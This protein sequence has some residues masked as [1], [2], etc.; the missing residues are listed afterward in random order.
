MNLVFFT[1][2]DPFYVKAF[3]DEFLQ[4][5]TFLDEIK[6]I[7]ISKSM[8]KKSALK[9]AQQMYDFYGFYNFLRVGSQYSYRKLMGRKIVRNNGYK[10]IVKTYTLQQLARVYGLNVIERSDLNSRDFQD[11]IRQYNADLFISVAS[12]IIFKEELIK[13]PRLDCINIHHAPLPRYRGMMP[14]FWQIYHGESEVGITIHRINKGIDTGDIIIQNYI[15]VRENESLHKLMLR[16]KKEGARI[17]IQVIED[18][19]KGRISYKKMEGAGSYFTF[20]T[21]DDVTEFKRRGNRL[22]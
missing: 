6:A 10:D 14:N 11:Y 7:V 15:P 1:Q 4:H 5:Y 9:L 20:P 2:E 13:I 21:R 12:S 8:A 16:S 19:R 3:F 22:I 18:F 17:M